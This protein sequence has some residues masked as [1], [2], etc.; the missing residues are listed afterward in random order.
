V[1]VVAT[2]KPHEAYADSFIRDI[3]NSTKTI[4][5]VGASANRARPSYGVMAFLLQKGFLV[6]PVNPGLAGQELQGQ[7][8]YGALRDIPDPVDMI[9]V[10]RASD[11]VPGLVDEILELPNLPKVLWMQLNVFHEESASRAE[12]RGIKVVMNRC[13]VIEMHRLLL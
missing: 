9:D 11:S 8:V 13:P 6:T 12:A 4:A 5:L 3:L 1:N 7:K 10:F 2:A